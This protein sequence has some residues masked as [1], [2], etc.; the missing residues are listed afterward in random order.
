[1]VVCEPCESIEAGLKKVHGWEEFLPKVVSGQ[2]AFRVGWGQQ[3]RATI[4]YNLIL[5]Q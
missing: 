5:L 4:I 3:G 1:M 2:R